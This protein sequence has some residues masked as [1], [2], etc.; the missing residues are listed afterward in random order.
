MV[1]LL[2]L[3]GE[4][5]GHG[6]PVLACGEGDEVVV[7][8]K[9]WLGMGGPIQTLSA[10]EPSA[11]N[12]VIFPVYGAVIFLFPTGIVDRERGWSLSV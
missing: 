3:R 6:K 4:R 5:G 11:V 9:S 1:H 7:Q 8:D 10:G 2:R 12:I